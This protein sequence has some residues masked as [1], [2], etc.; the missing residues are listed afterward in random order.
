MDLATV[1]GIVGAIGLVIM[2]MFMSSNGDIGMFGDGPSTVI[3][4]GGSIFIVLSNF[5][6]GQFLG[7]G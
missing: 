4:F 6:M 3:V 5:T 1:I 2:A 7:I